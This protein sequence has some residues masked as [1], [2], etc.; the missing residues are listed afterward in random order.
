MPRPECVKE[1]EPLA[2]YTTFKIGGPADFFASVTTQTEL[3]DVLQWAHDKQLDIHVLGGGSNVVFADAGFRGV[4]VQLCLPGIKTVEKEDAV[5]VSVGAGVE[6]DELVAYTTVHGW[7]GLE[8][9]SAIPGS[10]GAAPIQNIGAYG[11]EVGER[12]E[13]VRV[14]S[15][16]DRTEQVLS[17]ADCQFGY[18]DSIFKQTVGRD[19]IVTE[20]TFKLS[21]QPTPVTHYPDVAAALAGNATPALSE[22]R[23]AIVAIRA[24]KFPDLTKIGTAGSF[25][26]NPIV[27]REQYE[28]LKA[29]YPN[30]PGH[31]VDEGV[32]LS[33]AWL[34]DTV[35]SA[36]G[37]RAGDV[38]THQHHALVF[39]NHAYATAAA[40]DVFAHE[41]ADTIKNKT[42]VTLER[43]VNFI[44]EKNNKK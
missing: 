24:K 25:F 15:A 14:V 3:N 30:I 32:K 33:A 12:I 21:K 44:A 34:I 36:R 38:G 27:S 43:E 22:I 18:R 19:L 29:S 42:G 37:A 35:A 4:V 20:V 28:I 17:A 31:V 2:P 11:V 23:E 9:L 1:Q 40:L 7:W 8:N 39:V 10:V 41:I 13:S 16:A 26:K 5:F 6:W